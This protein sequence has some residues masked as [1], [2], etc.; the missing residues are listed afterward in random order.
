MNEI[1]S[2]LLLTDIIIIVFLLAIK[3]FYLL[4]CLV[5]AMVN[6]NAVYDPIAKRIILKLAKKNKTWKTVAK[7][8]SLESKGE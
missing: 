4:I 1:T 2:F 5:L 8:L 6:S 3:M 7:I